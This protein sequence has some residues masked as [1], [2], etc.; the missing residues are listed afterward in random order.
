MTHTLYTFHP[1]LD[2]AVYEAHGLRAGA[3]VRVLVLDL[4]H[5]VAAGPAGPVTVRS[6]HLRLDPGCFRPEPVDHPAGLL[7]A[8]RGE[9]WS[10]RQVERFFQLQKEQFRNP[11]GLPDWRYEHYRTGP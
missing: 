5:V 3:A 2:S 4:H 11:T 6:A 1:T 9:F 10:F 7:A 8:S